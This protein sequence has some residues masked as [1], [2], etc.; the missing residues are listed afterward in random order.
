MIP[1]KTLWLY[2]MK[3]RYIYI[4]QISVAW[5]NIIS[6]TGAL[7]CPMSARG[8]QIL[9]WEGDPLIWCCVGTCSLWFLTCGLFY[10]EYGDY[11][12][13]QNVGS[14]NIYMAQ[15]PRRWHSLYIQLLPGLQD[16][17]CI[18]NHMWVRQGLHWADRPFCGHEAEGALAAHPSWTSDKSAMDDHSINLGHCIQFHNTWIALLGRPLRLRSIQTIWSERW[19]LSH[20]VTEAFHLL[21]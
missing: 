2:R 18:K 17:T 12:F 21:L 9:S 11:M 1:S 3:K 15:R 13:I 16:T 10:P 6:K 8:N 7:T 19:L 14:H 4:P 20:Q 5:Q